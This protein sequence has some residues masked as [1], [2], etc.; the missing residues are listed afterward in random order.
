M[1]ICVILKIRP[2]YRPGQGFSAKYVL[3]MRSD[4]VRLRIVHSPPGALHTARPSLIV[5]YEY[6]SIPL[7]VW[8][9]ARERS[10]NQWRGVSHGV[11][12]WCPKAQ[13]W[14]RTMQLK[15]RG[16]VVRCCRCLLNQLI[17]R[18]CEGLT[19]DNYK[20]YIKTLKVLKDA[21]L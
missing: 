8:S 12:G 10:C 14:L 9:C 5:Y 1:S 21:L 20:T 15:V 11:L 4:F 13:V 17:W 2:F 3:T 16:W 18:R 19:A 7:D 6:F